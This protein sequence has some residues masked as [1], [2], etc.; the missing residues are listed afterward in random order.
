MKTKQIGPNTFRIPF[1]AD[2]ETG[3]EPGRFEEIQFAEINYSE[4]GIRQVVTP[5]VDPADL[6][7]LA[8]SQLKKEKLPEVEDVNFEEIAE[9]VRQF[10]FNIAAAEVE[11]DE[12][13][14]EGVEGEIP[15]FDPGADVEAPGDDSQEG[16]ADEFVGGGNF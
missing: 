15:T 13:T 1:A 11:E 6:L 10:R 12:L 8:M 9:K 16:E 4:N 7:K 3:F 5:G 2:T 14:M